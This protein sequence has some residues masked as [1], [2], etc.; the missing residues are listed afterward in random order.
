MGADLR[1][2]EDAL[3]RGDLV[4]AEAAF[5]RALERAPEDPDALY[6]LGWTWHLAGRPSQ[7]RAAFQQLVTLHPDSHL[8]YKGLGSVAMAEGQAQVAR[9]QLDAALKRAPTDL[10]VR[11]SLGLVDLAQGRPTEALARFDALLT[12]EPDRAELHQARAEA[13]LR[14]DRQEEAQRAAE[15]A[16]ACG[17]SARTRAVSHVT[18]ARVLLARSAG[19]VDPQDCRGT[20]PPVYAWLEEADRTLDVAAALSATTPE[21]AEARRLVRRRRA[22]VDDLCPGLRATMGKEF[23]GG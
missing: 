18:R 3:A 8:G 4:E 11:Q 9:A 20:A 14:L 13:L 17:G 15:T 2:G 22:A 23:P 21:L 16:I 12:E 10:A 1:A 19:R 5:R 6:G 7:A